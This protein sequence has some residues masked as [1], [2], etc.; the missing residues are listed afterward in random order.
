MLHGAFG[1]MLD[2]PPDGYPYTSPN[3][4]KQKFR[5]KLKSLF[6]AIMITT[7]KLYIYIKTDK[8]LEFIGRGCQGDWW[9]VHSHLTDTIYQEASLSSQYD[10]LSNAIFESCKQLLK[11]PK[12]KNAFWFNNTDEQ[13]DKCLMINKQ[14]IHYQS[15]LH[16]KKWNK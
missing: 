2:W 1:Q 3:N 12:R 11:N 10:Q 16:N 9:A 8:K 4:S 5:Q 14:R 6:H 15:F 7:K 13:I